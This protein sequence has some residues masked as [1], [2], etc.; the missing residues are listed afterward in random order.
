MSHIKEEKVIMYDSPE[1]AELVTVTVYKVN[2]P[3]GVI[4]TP[5]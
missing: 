2:N 3:N 4:Y 1:A 5:K